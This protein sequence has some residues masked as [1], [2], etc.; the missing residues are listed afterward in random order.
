MQRQIVIYRDVDSS[1]RQG[2]IEYDREADT[3]A[4]ASEDLI[5][6]VGKPYVELVLTLTIVRVVLSEEDL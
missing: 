4:G 1:Q 3:I 2:W 5:R 6:Y